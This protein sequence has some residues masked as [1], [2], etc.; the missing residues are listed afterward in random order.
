M[1]VPQYVE[2]NFRLYDVC[3]RVNDIVRDKNVVAGGGIAVRRCY[4]CGAI[5]HMAYECFAFTGK[6]RDAFVKEPYKYGKFGECGKCTSGK[7]YSDCCGKTDA[8]L[9]PPPRGFPRGIPRGGPRGIPRG[10]PRGIPRGGPRGIPRGAPPPPSLPPPL[11][12]GGLQKKKVLSEKQKKRAAEK[13]AKEEQQRKRRASAASDNSIVDED[14]IKQALGR[15]KVQYEFV[16]CTRTGDKIRKDQWESYSNSLSTEIKPYLFL[17][18]ERNAGNHKEL[19]YRTNCGFVLNLAWEVANFFPG[20]F[21]YLK[22]F[23]SD[24]SDNAT[25]LYAQLD[26][27]IAFVDRARA[28]NSAIL[29]HCV[30]GIS[31]S[32]TIVIAYLMKRENMTLK[33]AYAHVKNLR[34]LIRP[35]KGFLTALIKLDEKLHGSSS[36]VLEEYFPPDEVFAV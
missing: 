13:L 1:A 2:R 34:P 8:A 22:M 27:A 10:G 6:T 5:G 21:E 30:Q 33:D 25:D 9:V 35:N 28:S 7:K 16:V 23:L 11:P 4:F 19:G 20:E 31:R 3:P 15:E 26:Q 36:I 17:G 32:S 18:G 14:A 12:A 29:V 24:F